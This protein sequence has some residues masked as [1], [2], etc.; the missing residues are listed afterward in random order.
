MK[1]HTCTIKS[2][3]R[4]FLLLTLLCLFLA[5]GC[6]RIELYDPLSDVYLK[7]NLKLNTD[8]KLNED[9][10]L[11]GD[12]ALREKVYGKMPEKVRACFY[13]AQTHALVAEEFLPP[14]G[15]FIDIPAGTYDIIVYSLGNE[16]TQTEGTATRAGA[17]AFTSYLGSSLTIRSKNEEN[18][19]ADPTISHQP[20]IYEPDHIFVG[21]KENVVIPIRAE[22]DKTLVIEMDM[23]TLLDTYSLEVR[24]IQGVDRISKIDVYITGQAQSKYMWDRRFP[25]KVCAIYFPSEVNVNKGNLYTVFNTF[26]KFPGAHNDVYL[27]V[28]VTGTDGGHYQWIYDVTDQFDNPDNINHALIIDEDIIIPEKSEDGFRPEVQDWNT[29]IIYVPLS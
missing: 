10:D 2:M 3:R 27:N 18:P 4:I 19:E 9:I 21:T 7:L 6:K 8:V 24:S 5:T 12:A 28:L 22:I 26:G 14:T 23:T 11:E 13:S 20:I 17:Y 29:E 15:G 16:I 25:S 1:N